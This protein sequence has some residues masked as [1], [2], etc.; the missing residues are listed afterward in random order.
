MADNE[1]EEGKGRVFRM[2]AFKAY[3]VR[4]RAPAPALPDEHG[5]PVSSSALLRKGD[6]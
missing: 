5:Q 1:A 4:S 2:A 6:H 3:K